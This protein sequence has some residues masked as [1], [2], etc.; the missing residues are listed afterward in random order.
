MRYLI[1]NLVNRFV[2]ILQGLHNDFKKF[3]ILSLSFKKR[4]LKPWTTQGSQ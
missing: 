1:I 3:I 4:L 2:R